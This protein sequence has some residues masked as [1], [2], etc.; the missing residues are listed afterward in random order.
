M[1]IKCPKDNMVTFLFY[2]GLMTVM[3]FS[4]NAAGF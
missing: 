4:P 3:N 1:R 2:V